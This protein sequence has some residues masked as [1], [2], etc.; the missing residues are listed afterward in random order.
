MKSRKACEMYTKKFLNQK[1]NV[2][3]DRCN[4]DREQRKTWIE[5]AQHYKVPID[6]IVLT[7]DQTECG[8]RILVRENHPTGVSGNEGIH[9]LR[10]FVKN[11]HPPTLDGG[12][13]FSR[14]LY[15]NPS[16]DPVCTTERINE[17][18][19]LLEACPLLIPEYVPTHYEKPKI[20]IDSDGWATIPK[21][22]NNSS[23]NKQ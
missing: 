15:L 12:E 4:F 11:Y 8:N 17:I 18:F 20:T 5:I 19:T 10:R 2:I 22:N 3:I 1:Q 16:P 7:A 6:C 23:D 13:G 9:V 21:R 14:I